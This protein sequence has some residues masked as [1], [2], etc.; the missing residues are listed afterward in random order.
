MSGYYYST[1]TTTAYQAFMGTRYHGPIT[2]G[3]T[4]NITSIGVYCEEGGD[5]AGNIKIALYN[6]DTTPDL[7]KSGGYA[8]LPGEGSPGWVD[9]DI[10]ADPL[11]V[12][13]SDIIRVAFQGSVKANLVGAESGGNYDGGTYATFPPSALTKNDSVYLYRTRIYITAAGGASPV[14]LFDYYFNNMRP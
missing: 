11:A 8:A 3:E 14:P 5:G 7:Q 1:T 6:N 13:S 4:G 9:I 2:C 12:N 10:S